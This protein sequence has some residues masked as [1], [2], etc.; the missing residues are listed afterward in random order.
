MSRAILPTEGYTLGTTSGIH[1]QRVPLT[2]DTKQQMQL[3]DKPSFGHYLYTLLQD[4]LG[5]KG[6]EAEIVIKR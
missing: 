5:A 1:R 3:P 6:M 2:Q 4:G